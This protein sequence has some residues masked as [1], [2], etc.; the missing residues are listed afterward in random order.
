MRDRGG[1]ARTHRHAVA[2]AR[3]RAA[4]RRSLLPHDGGV[5]SSRRHR[6]VA[7]RAI[8]GDP[9]DWAEFLV[10]FDAAVDW[11][12]AAFWRRA[13]RRV[14][15]RAGAA[16]DPARSTTGGRARA[17]RSSGAM[18]RS[19]PPDPTV[20]CAD[21]D[22]DATCS[23]RGSHPDWTDEVEAK[24]GLRAPQRRR[25]ARP[26]TRPAG[27]V[28]PGR[29]L[30]PL[31]AALR[32]PV[33]DEPF[34]HVNTT[35]DFRAMIGGRRRPPDRR[36]CRDEP[37]SVR[38][39]GAA[40]P[41][42]ARRPDRAGCRAGATGSRHCV[43]PDDTPSTFTPMSLASIT[44]MPTPSA[45]ASDARHA[46]RV[47]GAHL[48]V[49]VVGRDGAT[50]RAVDRPNRRPGHPVEHA[51]DTERLRDRGGHGGREDPRAR[52]PH[53]SRAPSSPGCRA[54][55]PDAVRPTNRDSSRGERPHVHVVDRVRATLADRHGLLADRD[56]V[57]DRRARPRRVRPSGRLQRVAR[58]E[59]ARAHR[60]AGV[61]DTVDI[62]A[63]EQVPLRVRREP[64][65][66][67]GARQQ[68]AERP[69]R[70]PRV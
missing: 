64:L 47:V 7:A 2:Q 34:P 60:D 26:S 10:E 17:T 44:A 33:P 30:G 46:L 52:P 50:R 15:G 29:R 23:R 39:G 36:R 28:A 6:G 14:P 48:G 61:G 41:G 70:H 49:A 5:R 9:P 8:E 18:S 37:G 62:G 43:T 27:R 31:C 32:V 16:V 53:G 3:A 40:R 1:G 54:R 22:G 57:A 45:T 38:R 63:G 67:R 11:P 21:R 51:L 42:S 58:D 4:A 24:R 66:R 13:R 12:V 35:D 69:I 19:L 20:S 55:C 56:D 65:E 59:Q 25:C 68:F